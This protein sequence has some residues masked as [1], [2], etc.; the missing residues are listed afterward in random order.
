MVVGLFCK[1][2]VIIHVRT[3]AYLGCT[4]TAL[5]Y[6]WVSIPG[7][8]GLKYGRTTQPKCMRPLL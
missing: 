3:T 5:V 1:K 6:S 8:Y 4:Y 7:Q 2:N